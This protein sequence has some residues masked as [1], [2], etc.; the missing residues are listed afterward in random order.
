MSEVSASIDGKSIRGA[1]RR[2]TL[3]RG[4]PGMVALTIH[5]G[6]EATVIV[7][8]AVLRAELDRLDNSRK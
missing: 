7:S 1:R 4:Q 2:L 8:V 3:T 5:A 6:S